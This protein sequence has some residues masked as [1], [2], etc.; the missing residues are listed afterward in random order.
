MEV[1]IFPFLYK[2]RSLRNKPGHLFNNKKK[3]FKR[4]LVHTEDHYCRGYSVKTGL[5]SVFGTIYL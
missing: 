2:T 3:D 4:F 1:K 5:N